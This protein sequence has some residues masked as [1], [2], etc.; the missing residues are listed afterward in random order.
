[1]Y[2]HLIMKNNICF[3][4]KVLKRGKDVASS[5]SFTLDFSASCSAFIVVPILLLKTQSNESSLCV[6]IDREKQTKGQNVYLISGWK[7][8]IRKSHNLI[9]TAYSFRVSVERRSPGDEVGNVVILS[10]WKVF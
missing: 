3:T 10:K 7:T 4:S 5:S 1:M 2:I 6:C 8:Q 9:P